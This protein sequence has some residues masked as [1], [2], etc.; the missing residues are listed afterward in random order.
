M[1]IVLADVTAADWLLAIV[2]AVSAVGAAAGA[3]VLDRWISGR[4][5]RQRQLEDVVLE[6]GHLLPRV[7]Q[8]ISEVYDDERPANATAAGSEW[9][10]QRER[11]EMLLVAIRSRYGVGQPAVVAAAEDLAARFIA[12][13]LDFKIRR[14]TIPHEELLDISANELYRLVF[15]KVGPLDEKINQYRRPGSLTRV[16]PSAT[17]GAVPDWSAADGLQL[18]SVDP[19]TS[20]P[21]WSNS[22]NGRRGSGTACAASPPTA[23]ST[24]SR[25]VAGARQPRR[26]F[27]PD[28]P[29]RTCA[30]GSPSSATSRRVGRHH[31]PPAQDPACLAAGRARAPRRA[32]HRTP[33][34]NAAPREGALC[35]GV[36]ARRRHPSRTLL[37]VRSP[38]P[39]C[40][41]ALGLNATG[42]GGCC[43][44]VY[45]CG[46]P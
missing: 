43:G 18:G 19:P 32:A 13:D 3:V 45:R 5:E 33:A 25:F 26:R 10:L 16:V 12:A 15:P 6:L 29:S 4:R 30:R 39:P 1:P 40:P 14:V 21:P 46:R 34:R 9:G 27:A 11:V 8:V 35:N 44:H 41:G 23:T 20:T 17:I 7:T 31:R 28:A 24:S 36:R 38:V 2:T 22:S 37:V 42:L